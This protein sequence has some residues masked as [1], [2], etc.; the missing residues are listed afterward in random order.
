MKSFLPKVAGMI[1][2]WS[3]RSEALSFATVPDISNGLWDEAYSLSRKAKFQSFRHP[4]TGLRL[5]RDFSN[6]PPA[7]P[8][9]Q[10]AQMYGKPSA[11]MH[12][13]GDYVRFLSSFYVVKATPHGYLTCSCEASLKK[14]RCAH[15]VAI[16]IRENM[17]EVPERLTSEPLGMAKKGPGRPKKTMGGFNK[18]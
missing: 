12:S 17:V 14:Y 7:L 2:A 10:C 3:K 11:F 18:K 13:Y 16:E 8:L 9:P 1:E 4:S 6:G 15:S 5:V